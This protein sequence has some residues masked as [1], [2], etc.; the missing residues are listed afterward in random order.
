M[1]TIGQVAK[2]L[3]VSRDTLKFYEEKGLVNPEKDDKNG[4]RK[5]NHFDIEEV[6]TTNFYREINIEIKEIQEIRKGK[7][8]EDIE[9]LLEEKEEEI[10]REIEY[11]NLLLKRIKSVKEDCKR[12]KQHFGGYTITEMKPVEV[13]S[14][15]TNFFA[16]N[17]FKNLQKNTDNLKE[18][19]TL[20]GA[21]RV[22]SVDE[23][24]INGNRFIVVRKVEDLDK[25]IEG[26]VIAYSKCIYTIIEDS[27]ENIDD[28]VGERI[29]KIAED[30][31]YELIGLVFVG[32]LLT[33]Y[34][35]GVERRFLEIYTPIK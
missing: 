24:G 10:L 16:Y 32:V 13:K 27:Y 28:E 29:K 23:E 20:T 25:D 3:G 15:I 17:E 18:A 19:V 7:S 31:G 5:Y 14:E 11:K 21:M 1:Y 35:E 4:Y 12:I 6:L 22:I 8:V 9:S 30:N 34:E 26:E 2:F 33:T